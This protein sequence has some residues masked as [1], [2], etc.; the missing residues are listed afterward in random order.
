MAHGPS[1][2]KLAVESGVWPLLRFDPRRVAAGEPPLH[3]DS[4]PAKA[5]VTDYMR[6]EARFRMV[7]K[8][9]PVRFK[10]LAEAAQKTAEQ[11]AS[12][13]QQL[14]ALTIPKE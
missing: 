10:L 1:Q 7:E 2:Q 11:R 4:G 3:L 6:N 8:V 14:S 9:D 13:Y 5:K 12:V